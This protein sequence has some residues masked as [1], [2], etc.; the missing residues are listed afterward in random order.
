MPPSDAQQP[1]V[2]PQ[3]EATRVG[4]DQRLGDQLDADR[5]AGSDQAPAT[6]AP[7][8]GRSLASLAARQRRRA[9]ATTA[10]R[11][12]AAWVLLLGAYYVYPGRVGTAGGAAVKL[13]VG[14]LVLAAVVGVEV[15]SIV[16]ARLPELRAV[17][18]L[19]VTLVLFLVVFAGI[20][21]SVGQ[22]PQPMFSMALD[23]AR[24]L[25][26]TVTVFSTVG[27]GDIVPTTDGVRLVVATQMLLD[28]VFI[29]AV[30]RILVLAARRGLDRDDGKP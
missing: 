18:A 10:L 8:T 17:E 28:L 14:M 9:I 7:A 6:Q 3:R 19:G 27:F 12:A 4:A 22:G 2:T 15:R 26:F 24:A 5:R 16:A 11:I 20:Y 13:A 23:H 1:D 30:A 25:Y 21:L 29:G